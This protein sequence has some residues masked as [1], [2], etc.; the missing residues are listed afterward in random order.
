MNNHPVNFGSVFTTHNGTIRND[1][2]LF[3]DIL[4]KERAAE[5]DTEII[6]ALLDHFTFDQAHQAFEKLLGGFA[7]ASI[8]P[9]RYKG[10]VLLAK[11]PSWPLVFHENKHF[12]V[13]ASTE[14]A[15]KAAWGECLGTPSTKYEKLEEG[16]LYFLGDDVDRQKKA[17]KYKYV[18]GTS[19]TNQHSWQD[20]WDD[21]ETYCDYPFWFGHK[22]DDEKKDHKPQRGF[23][24]LDL[25]DEIGTLRREGK[26]MGVTLLHKSDP[27]NAE[28]MEKYHNDVW[29]Y[30]VHCKDTISGTQIIPSKEWGNI[31]VDCFSAAKRQESESSTTSTSDYIDELEIDLDL[32]KK[33]QSYADIQAYLHSQ[34][35]FRLVRDTGIKRTVLDFILFRSPIEY[36]DSNEDIS[37]LYCDLS[38][39]Y[40]EHFAD[41]VAQYKEETEKK[42]DKPAHENGWVVCAEGT[43]HVSAPCKTCERGYREGES[44]GVEVE[45][46]PAVVD[47]KKCLVCK[48]KTKLVVGTTGAWCKKHGNTCTGSLERPY[49]EGCKEDPIGFTKEDGHRWC[50]THSRGRK[51]FI[52]DMDKKARERL[53]KEK[54]RSL[55]Y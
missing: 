15:I 19:S 25:E 48:R 26:G 55:A 37:T 44:C 46:K 40:Q 35:L 32:F 23:T 4:E 17:F 3:R 6:P 8:D 41:L 14:K 28:F 43:H 31:C 53:H 20:D 50:H 36:L 33:V 13:W 18:G 22:K 11:G 24:T 52:A 5:V 51:G 16:D 42:A 27:R 10:L 34:A 54:E 21:G 38:D 47:L 39:K 49:L 7:T 29:V 45:A 9:V 12:V 1:D 30:C 2:R